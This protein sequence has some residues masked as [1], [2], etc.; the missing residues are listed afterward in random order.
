MSIPESRVE[1]ILSNIL[2]EDYEVKLGKSRVEDLLIGIAGII[3]NTPQLD[4]DGLIPISY[5]PKDAFQ[6]CVTVADDTARFALTTDDVQNGD[7]V[8][9][10]SSQI[11]YFVVDDTKLDQ[12]AGYK[13]L[14]A[15]IAAQ[16]VAD[17]NG[18]DIT[19]TY[20]T[21]IDSQHKL[22]ADNVDDSQSTNK[23][24]MQGDWS[25]TT[26]S[27]G[28][29]IKNKPTLGTASALDVATTGDASTTQVV[30]GDDS[31]LTDNR[32]PLTHNQASDTINAMS[33]YSKA[34]AD[35]AITTSDTLNTAIG[36]L[37]YKVDVNKTN[38]LLKAN[39]ADVNTTTANLQA[40]IN[41]IITPV[42]QDA[43][44]ENARVSADGT[45]YQTLKA[46]LDA[47][48]A[49]LH[50]EISEI[51]STEYADVNYTN[52]STYEHTYA[53]YFS[54]AGYIANSA[55]KS[56][57]MRVD[58]DT[59]IYCKSRNGEFFSICIYPDSTLTSGVRYRYVKNDEDT[60]PYDSAPLRVEKGKYIAFS[61]SAQTIFE[62]FDV[63]FE[64]YT[65]V[66]QKLDSDIQLNQSQINQVLELAGA[67]PAYIK[68]DGTASGN[69]VESL[70]VFL[71]TKIGYVRYHIIHGTSVAGNY[72][73]WRIEGAYAT[74]TALNDRFALTTGGEW[75]MAVKLSG[76]PD[77]SGGT[78]HGDE[79]MD[80]ITFFVD[81]NLVDISDFTEPTVFSD[82]QFVQVSKVYNA[83][84]SSQQIATHTSVH[85]FKDAELTINQTLLWNLP[86]S[87]QLSAAYMA[88]H[89]P[90]KAVTD[91]CYTDM[92]FIPETCLS[93][94]GDTPNAKYVSVYGDTSGVKTDFW[95]TD[96]PTGLSGGDK[97]LMTDNGGGSYNKCYYVVAGNT[98]WLPSGE[99][100]WKTS[101]HYRFTVGK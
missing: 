36:K 21:V 100:L 78:T 62:Y 44:V 30:K 33:G 17:K 8:Y 96:Y 6:D 12:A 51:V 98:A 97:L 48:Y 18:N 74:D 61:T 7:C 41:N 22:S 94:Y 42:T 87:T 20:Q 71:P 45:S 72:D 52:H 92:A 37:E 13:A 81:G 3:A 99:T 79:V 64:D 14:A 76:N 19:T 84:D 5:I 38:I 83:S 16:A 66:S 1:A 90:A 55:Y 34:Q 77:F 11:M 53:G 88:M 69:I 39:I 73:I 10:N 57:S 27:A 9:V 25:Q 91:H 82:F 101:T 67:K 35:S 70:D 46:R 86:E 65:I 29:Y 31:R 4:N 28:D 23:F 80:S 63:V 95:I 43:E 85:Q 93:K 24:N 40:Q 60:L 68:Y 56:Y 54:A 50:D 89:L 15:G 47:E 58:R 59:E 75:E 26:S 32:N 2:G 49:D